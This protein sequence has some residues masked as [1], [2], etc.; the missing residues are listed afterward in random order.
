MASIFNP[1]E[2]HYEEA[3]KQ[4]KACSHTV[5]QIANAASRAEIRDISV[6]SRHQ[7]KDSQARDQK[8]EAMQSQMVVM[9]RRF[10]DRLD[11]LLKVSISKSRR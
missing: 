5:E 7:H 4:I 1:F 8:L 11:E 10:D 2:L 9:Q 3:V 6:L